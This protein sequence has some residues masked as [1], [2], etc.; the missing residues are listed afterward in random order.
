MGTHLRQA[1]DIT[2]SDL[3]TLVSSSGLIPEQTYRITDFRTRHKIPGIQFGEPAEWNGDISLGDL[4]DTTTEPLIVTAETSSALHAV[5]T[6]DLFPQDIIHYELVDS[7]TQGGDRGRITYREDTLQKIKVVNDFRN[8]R[9]KRYSC[10]V[11]GSTYFTTS[12][13]GTIQIGNDWYISASNYITT[14]Y[15][16]FFMFQPGKTIYDVSILSTGEYSGNSLSDIVFHEDASHV[17]IGGDTNAVTFCN[18]VYDVVMEG[19]GEDCTFMSG[20]DTCKFNSTLRQSWI[21]CGL[22]ALETAGGDLFLV[23][24]GDSGLGNCQFTAGGN[25]E[26]VDTQMYNCSFGASN[27]TR[28]ITDAINHRYESLGHSGGIWSCTYQQL[29]DWADGS[30]LFPGQKYRITDFRTRHYTP[31]VP[32]YGGTEWSALTTYA[33][34]EYA[35]YGVTLWESVVNDNINNIPVEGANWTAHT[36][37]VVEGSVEPIVVTAIST[38]ELSHEVYSETYPQDIIHYELTPSAFN[39]TRLPGSDKGFIFYRKDLDGDNC[40]DFDI[41]ACLWR[42]WLNV[43]NGEFELPTTDV[44]A[45]T[46][47]DFDS[48]GDSYFYIPKT[49]FPVL[50]TGYSFR[51][52]LTNSISWNGSYIVDEVTDQDDYWRVITQEVVNFSGITSADIIFHDYNDY[53]TFHSSCRGNNLSL[54]F[55]W[56]E[57]ASVNIVLGENCFGNKINGSAVHLY[58]ICCSNVLEEVY[59]VVLRSNCIN[60]RILHNAMGIIM[61]TLC[62]FNTIEYHGYAVTFGDRCSYNFIGAGASNLVLEADIEDC[63]INGMPEGNPGAVLNSLISATTITTRKHEDL[64]GARPWSIDY[65]TLAGQAIVELLIPGQKYRIT[66]R[67]DAIV[68]TTSASTYRPYQDCIVDMDWDWTEDMASIQYFG[69]GAQIDGRYADTVRLRG[70][71]GTYGSTQIFN[72]VLGQK[73]RFIAYKDIDDGQDH[74]YTFIGTAFESIAASGPFLW[75]G[76]IVINSLYGDWL[77][78]EPISITNGNGTFTVWKEKARSIYVV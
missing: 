63:V 28:V 24:T 62:G 30:G 23:A 73:V 71:G 32:L 8:V 22:D 41:R 5:A 65:D 45:I 16:H 26:F 37:C 58:D 35:I 50:P 47:T 6:S 78:L 15:D 67:A 42:R 38:T 76:D 12:P 43:L 57:R 7:T 19:W 14:G 25:W 51:M 11:D 39:E 66:D 31:S 17:R 60:N 52:V 34:G 68:E 70:D 27:G 21:E 55:G 2:Y 20:V 61:G 74:E 40:A 44:V 3:T 4:F 46:E 29:S 33:S 1:I 59:S 53:A 49:N 75:Q 64:G 54:P 48:A 56:Q 72:G 69:L 9:Y 18:Y 10:E 13:T 77:E 36:V